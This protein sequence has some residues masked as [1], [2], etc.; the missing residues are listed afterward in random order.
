MRIQRARSFWGWQN[1]G[2]SDTK[3][4]LIEQLRVEAFA[5]LALSRN[6]LAKLHLVTWLGGRL[7]QAVPT[8]HPITSEACCIA[9]NFRSARGAMAFC[10]RLH[11]NWTI[12]HFFH[13]RNQGR[14][15]S[16]G[17]VVGVQCRW[18]TRRLQRSS[19][20]GLLATGKETGNP[21]YALFS[22]ATPPPDSVVA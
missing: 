5:C 8:L 3:A 13:Y 18:R 19:L 20:D 6:Q 12:R 15:T 11:P 17:F 4:I 10:Q 14:R 21:A 7:P 2:R 9:S 22:G 16:A 1:H